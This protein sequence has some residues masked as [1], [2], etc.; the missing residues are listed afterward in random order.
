MLPVD[1]RGQAGVGQAG[2]RDD[3]VAATGGAAA[4]LISTG[5]GGAVEA[6]HVDAAWPRARSGRRRSRCPGSMRP[7]SSMVTWVWSGTWRPSATMARRAPLMAALAW[8][9]SNDRLDEE[10]V[11]AALEQPGGLLLVGVAQL[12]VGDLPQGGELGA[13][14]H[15]AGHPA[16]PVRGGELVGRPSG[17]ARRPGQVELAGPVGHA[18][19]R[20]GPTAKA[21]EGVGLHH[22]A[23]DLEEGAVDLVDE[24]RAG[25]STSSSLHPSRS[26]PPKS[27]AAQVQELQVRPHGAVEDDHPLGA[28]SR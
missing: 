17:Q 6:D 14:A 19:T 24:R 22:V 7:V 13:R 10:Q 28:A 27:S 8:S 18:R 23:A 5:P 4:S 2:D 1:H 12:G 20:P 9:R 15:A 16:G 3:G 26:G 25:C 11:D 21:A